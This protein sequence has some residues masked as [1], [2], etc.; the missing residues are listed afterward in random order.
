[1][2]K[3]VEYVQKYKQENPS[4]WRKWI[5]GALAALA[6][7]IL[8]IAYAVQTALR[9]REIARLKHELDVATV[10]AEKAKADASV[11]EHLEARDEAIGRAELAEEQAE[12]LKEQLVVLEA[13]HKRN[14]DLINSI[15]SWEDVD[16]KIR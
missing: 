16:A 6:V 3:L 2:N 1:M 13:D 10:G 14:E 11:A 15:R 8:V 5:F 7:L 4:G 9:A 12:E